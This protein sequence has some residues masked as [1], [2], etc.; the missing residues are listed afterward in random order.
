MSIE[1][2]E[3]REKKLSIRTKL[4]QIIN[5]L[6]PA[7]EEQDGLFEA[8][9]KIK[10]NSYN[11]EDYSLATHN[12]ND[13]YASTVHSHNEYS[14]IDHVHDIYSNTNHNHDNEY[15]LIA[16]AHNEYSPIDHTH[17]DY[18]L[19]TH[20]H[21]I[22]YAP[23]VHTHIDYSLTTH[24]HDIN[25][26]PIVHTHEDYS[27]ITHEHDEYS[28]IGH[29][30]DVADILNLNSKV[31]YNTYKTKLKIGFAGDSIAQGIGKTSFQSS[32][33]AWLNFTGYPLDLF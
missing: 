20:E 1:L 10:L 21:D 4:N 5:T 33:L 6:V 13:D 32:F 27:L 14:P 31:L 18:S 3:N 30:H 22:N 16:H 7:T 25:Y 15:S 23:I 19:I 9:D 11:H 24:E 17:I 12:H 2:I 26:A 8:Q 29:S 28:S